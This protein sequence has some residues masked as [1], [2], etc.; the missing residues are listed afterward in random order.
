CARDSRREKP[1]PDAG[2]N[3]IDIPLR[4]IGESRGTDDHPIKVAGSDD[5]LLHFLVCEDVAQEQGNGN[6]VVDY[7]ELPLAIADTERGFADKSLDPGPFHGP[8]DIPRAFRED[9][10]SPGQEEDGEDWHAYFD[11]QG[12]RP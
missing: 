3:A 10:L 1:V 9:G 8:H 11:E 2:A 7:A 12:S 5:S 6:Q 4:P